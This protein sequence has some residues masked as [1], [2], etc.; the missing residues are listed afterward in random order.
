M[1][2]GR[3]S[4]EFTPQEKP[5][6]DAEAIH[7]GLVDNAI[8][9]QQTMADEHAETLE[10]GRIV[11]RVET[12]EF[13]QTIS[14]S[15]KLS[16]YDSARNSKAYKKLINPKTKTYFGNIEEFCQVVLGNGAERMR[17]I[18]GNRNIVGQDLF[19]R[20]ERLGL[21]QTDYNAIKALPHDDQALIQQAIA[22]ES[23]DDVFG[24]LQEFAARSQRE[25]EA[26]AKK[27]AETEEQLAAA[28]EII[29]RRDQTVNKQE[30]E[31]AVLTAKPKAEPTPELL[32][33]ERLRFIAEATMKTVADIEAGLRSHFTLLENL[34]PAGEIPN[35]ARLAQQQALS[36]IIQAARSLAGDFNIMLHTADLERPE[37]LWLTQAREIFGD[38]RM[39]EDQLGQTSIPSDLVDLDLIDKPES[40]D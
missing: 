34:F 19:E 12:A 32:G 21:R 39:T 27:Q 30:E 4:I 18:S 16:A 37:N 35:H 28:K 25:K 5:A 38:E 3:K 14:D 36:Q 2:A 24:L 13:Y 20:S 8:S 9:A 29:K 31:I 23:R 1:T 6:I 10:L 17:Q 26:A 33:E 40:E 22:T 15:I 7:S 11:G